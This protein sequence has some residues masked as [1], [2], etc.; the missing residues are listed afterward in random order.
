[1]IDALLLLT[2]GMF[3]GVG[4]IWLIIT[5]DWLLDWAITLIDGVK[6]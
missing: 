2:L 3:V 1:M 6:E 4:F 5:V